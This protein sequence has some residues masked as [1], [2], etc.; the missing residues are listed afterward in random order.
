MMGMDVGDMGKEMVRRRE[1]VVDRVN[2][3]VD[4]LAF[5]VFHDC[6]GVADR[7]RGYS[8]IANGLIEGC[9]GGK[10]WCVVS[11]SVWAACS[12]LWT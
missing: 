7:G 9:I 11:L 6:C 3:Q 1:Q 4:E 5:V 12:A 8:V 2:V 10:I